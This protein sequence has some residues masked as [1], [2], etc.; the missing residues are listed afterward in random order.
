[1]QLSTFLKRVLTL[2][3]IS[4]LAMG[5]GL[6]VGSAMLPAIT[7]LAG[8]LVFGA[9]LALVP[10]GAFILWVATRKRV[11]PLFVVAIVAGNIL[12]AAESILVADGTAGITALG[13]LLVLGQ[14]A[15]VAVLT[16]LEVV[17]LVRSTRPAQT[18]IA[19]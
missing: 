18:P 4:C 2:D 3:A 13:T 11:S 9:G 19:A 10:I 16:L 7:G 12:W 17:G 14:A 5:A 15:A 6:M 1:M 8:T